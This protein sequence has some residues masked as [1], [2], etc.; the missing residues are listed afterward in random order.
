MI[1]RTVEEGNPEEQIMDRPATLDPKSG[2]C[3]ETSIFHSKRAP[4]SLP[5]TP[6][7]DIFTFVSTRVAVS[8]ST[9]IALI[10]SLT[11]ESLSYPQLW[12]S[13]A[14]VASYLVDV[15][16]IKKGDVVL[17]LSPNSILFPV[18]SF[19]VMSIGAVLTTTNPLN[20]AGEISKQI[21]DSKP[22]L[23]FTVSLLVPKLC[24]ATSTFPVVLLDRAPPTHP[25]VV[26]SVFDIIKDGKGKI[27]RGLVKSSAVVT[28][29]DTAS[30]LYSSGTTGVSKGVIATHRNFIAMVE[31]VTRRFKL[32]TSLSS[33]KEIFICT[34][35]M[36]HIYGLAA[37]ATGLLATGATVVV[38]SKFEMGDLMSAIATYKATYFPL[39]PPI[40]IAMIQHAG[41]IKKNHNLSSLKKV[42]SGGAPLSK[43]I[44]QGFTKEYP[45]VEIL[46]GYGLTETTGMGSSTDSKEESERYGTAGLLS[47][48]T[49]ARIVDPD[50]FASLPVN[51][52][53][54]LWLRGSFVMKG[55]IRR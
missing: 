55:L 34:V 13:V 42:L 5:T 25:R 27:H 24:A 26:S 22:S 12:T 54:E 39:V 37:F 53:G 29:N 49:E 43:E 28:Q 50:T 48:N 1:R 38:V 8:T 15:H 21:S 9:N 16:N 44:I 31:I 52:T 20:T 32:D 14:S 30:L 51:K 45:T 23:A 18:V 33:E 10:D 47:P 41:T 6:N 35:P 19:A 7:L 46:Q 2:F 40:L 17:I 36:F 11:G 4:I 3:T